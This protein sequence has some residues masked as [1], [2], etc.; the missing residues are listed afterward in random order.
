VTST[1]EGCRD[2][3]A[4][5]APS[6]ASPSRSGSQGGSNHKR[7]ASDLIARTAPGTCATFE[8][9]PCPVNWGCATYKVRRFYAC[10][11]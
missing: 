4:H 5:I 3:D 11:R 6:F 10:L 8:L 1:F 2:G 9:H 7:A